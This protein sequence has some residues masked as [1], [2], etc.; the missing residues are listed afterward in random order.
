MHN[1]KYY[2]VDTTV[3]KEFQFET[4]NDTV[5][6]LEGACQ[7]KFGQSRKTYMDNMVSLGY[8]PDDQRATQFVRLM[9]EAFNVGVIRSN[10]KMRT[11]ITN[12]ERYN[13]SE[14]GD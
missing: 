3:N 1:M 5:K 4:F 6:H 11:D 12:I 7:R 9:T 14:F 8:S 10:G 13:K 2:I